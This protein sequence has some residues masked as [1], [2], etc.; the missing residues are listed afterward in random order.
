MEQLMIFY[1]ASWQ[2]LADMD[3]TPGPFPA[4][5]GTRTD[6]RPMRSARRTRRLEGPG[7][8]PDQAPGDQDGGGQDA[9]RPAASAAGQGGTEK[10]ELNNSS[11]W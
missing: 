4:S 11:W 7:Q 1:Y 5:A 9:G 2:E 3:D 10:E 8:G 6:P